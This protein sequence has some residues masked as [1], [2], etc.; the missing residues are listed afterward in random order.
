MQKTALVT[1]ASRGLGLS[2]VEEFRG[3]GWRVVALVRTA[4]DA[5]ILAGKEEVVP[6]LADIRS[7]QVSGAISQPL[8][9]LGGS[10]DALVNNAGQGGKGVKLDHL[11]TNVVEDLLNTHCLGAIRVTQAALPF[12]RRSESSAVIN[13]TSRFASLGL[14]AD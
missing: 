1:G 5:A 4:E 7:P 2:I 14:L 6:V 13:I 11:D 3:R 9:C 12:L 8:A 10:L